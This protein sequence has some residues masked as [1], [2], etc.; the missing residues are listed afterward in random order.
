MESDSI[1][2]TAP[3]PPTLRDV[4]ARAKVSMMTVSNVINA[5]TA[6]LSEQTRLR[7]VAAIDEL[8]YRPQRSA[9]GLRMQ[10]EYTIGL[11][12]VHPDRR[13]LDDP[14][15]TEVA[16]GM[17]NALAT[18]GFGLTINGVTDLDGLK[19]TLARV[20]NVDALAVMASGSQKLREKMYRML[21]RQYHPLAIIQ[22]EAPPDLSDACS[23]IQDDVAGAAMITDALIVAGATR[24]LFAAPRHTWPAVERR[25]AGVLAAAQRRA[26]VNR[27]TCNESDFE[28]SIAA[29]AAYIARRGVPDAIVAAND[30]IGIAAIRAATQLGIRVP[31]D[32]MVTGFNAFRFRQFSVPLIT[33]AA[34]PA[35]AI[36]E[37]VA[38]E[39]LRRTRKRLLQ[40]Q[41]LCAAGGDDG[42]RLHSL[43]RQRGRRPTQVWP[44]SNPIERAL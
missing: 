32:L 24:L 38:R 11:T 44:H 28:Q 15:I 42:R 35:Y 18:A 10:R 19:K 3:R 43:P 25:E 26:K 39:L 20:L 29:I 21:D 23:F 27:V 12:I 30:Q 37:E 31:E 13:F 4:A 16:A 34:S 40:K 6:R 5:R 17:S 7:I 2:R 1:V 8:G 9:R 36:G 22:D 33:S 41:G 14:Y